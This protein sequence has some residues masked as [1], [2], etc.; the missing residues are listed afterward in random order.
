MF[1]LFQA[2]WSIVLTSRMD[3]LSITDVIS[4]GDIKG[5]RLIGDDKLVVVRLQSLEHRR[6]VAGL[7]VFYL[8]HSE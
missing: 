1:E 6:K 8:I 3:L 5:R 7:A 4:Q 2:L